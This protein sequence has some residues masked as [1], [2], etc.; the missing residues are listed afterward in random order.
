MKLFNEMMAIFMDII[1]KLI[2]VTAERRSQS[3]PLEFLFDYYVSMLQ[4]HLKQSKLAKLWD[5]VLQGLQIYPSN[6]KL[7]E[8]LVEVGHRYTVSNRLRWIFDDFCHK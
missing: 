8:T 4:K 3:Y 2:S 6:P 7:L 1:T 5:A